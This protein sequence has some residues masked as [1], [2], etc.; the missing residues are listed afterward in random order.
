MTKG[1]WFAIGIGIGS[2]VWVST[3]IATKILAGRWILHP[4]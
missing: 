2:L 1:E 4:G 3:D